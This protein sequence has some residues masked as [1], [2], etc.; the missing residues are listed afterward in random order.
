MESFNKPLSFSRLKNLQIGPAYFKK[1]L[2]AE[3]KDSESLLL[4]GII[5]CLLTTPEKFSERYLLASAEKPTAMMWELTSTYLR[6]E[7]DYPGD[8][9]NFEKSYVKSGFKGDIESIQKR[10]D[11]E[12]KSY[13]EEQLTA[14]KDKKLLYTNDLMSK[15][16]AVVTSLLTNSYTNHYFKINDKEELFTQL[17]INWK[18]N[19]IDFKA[20][21]D[22][23]KIYHDRKE[24]DLIDV[25]T[26]G[27]S[28][29]TFENSIDQYQYWLQMVIYG[30]ALFNYLKEKNSELLNYKLNFKWMVESTVYPGTPVIYKMKES[31]WDKGLR[32]GFNKKGEKVKGLVELIADLI[33]YQTNNSWTYRREVIENNGEITANIFND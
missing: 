6:L 25:K 20:I 21:L 30:L 23:V 27:Y 22:M 14:T 4:G 1:M 32:G 5:D 18:I 12:G 29:D 17:E 31:D 10:F 26:T 19:N 7:K 24:I 11:K 28:V 16:E 13:F 15:A 33:W 2:N 8:P 3:E 9:S